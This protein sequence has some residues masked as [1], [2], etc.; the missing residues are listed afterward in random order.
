[1][2]VR[3]CE[4][5]ISPLSSNSSADLMDK[6]IKLYS[7]DPEN[8]HTASIWVDLKEPGGSAPLH[9]L[10]EADEETGQQATSSAPS[11]T[12]G[13]QYLVD[14]AR[15]AAERDAEPDSFPEKVR[16]LNTKLESVRKVVG[17]IGGNLAKV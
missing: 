6:E 8:N 14:N 10:L 17:E 4:Q 3:Q 5:I 16:R 1:M 11:S 7:T 12:G 15:A 13:V 9:G 2:A